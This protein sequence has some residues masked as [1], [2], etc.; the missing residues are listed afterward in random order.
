[1]IPAVIERWQRFSPGVGVAAVVALAASFLANR[2]GAP[3]MLLGLLLGMAFN[4]LAEVPK[5]LP[6]IDFSATQ[7]LRLGVALLGLRLT[8]DDLTALGWGPIVM[9]FTAVIATMLVGVL[10]ARV[11]NVDSKV[12][13]LTG[14]AVGICGAS[15]AMAISSAL[16]QGPETKRYTLFTV[17]G[18]TA[19]STIAMVLYP[20]IGGL[21]Q[22][23]DADMGLFIGATIHDVAQVVGAGYSVSTEAGDLGTFVKLLRVAMLVPVV[24]VIG[25]VIRSGAQGTSTRGISAPV[26]WFLVMFVLLFVLNSAGYMPPEVA[27][28]LADSASLL[29]LLAIAALGIRTSLKEVMTIG[30]RPVI[31]LLGET[32]FLAAVVVAYLMWLT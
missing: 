2:Y 14:G 13:I 10:L 17:I 11:L 4:F 18:V 28:P 25:I 20:V 32:L 8:M 29:L 21:L 23:S 31:L 24:L 5:L 6:G 26:P 27:R 1:M 9:V 15:A 30:F 7:I 3:A 12:G 19:L 22:F 16:P